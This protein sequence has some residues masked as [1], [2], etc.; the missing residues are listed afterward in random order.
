MT[1][2]TDKVVL[3]YL[4]AYL[5]IAAGIGIAGRVCELGVWHGDSLAMWQSLFPAGVVAGVD[6]HDSCTWPAGTVKLVCE[7]DDPALPAALAAH[8]P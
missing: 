2:A 5:S 8:S 6:R 1:F 4:P 3:G 7:Q